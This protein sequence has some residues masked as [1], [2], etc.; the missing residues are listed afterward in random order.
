MTESK[1]CEVMVSDGGRSPLFHRCPCVARGTLKTGKLA[2]GIH[3]G[4]ER[5]REAQDLARAEAQVISNEI[6][7][8]A[9]ANCVR[10]G[11]FLPHNSAIPSAPT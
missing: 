7:A 1:R 11:K 9:E 8:A 3:L 2:C 5:R 6:R 10:L 4:R